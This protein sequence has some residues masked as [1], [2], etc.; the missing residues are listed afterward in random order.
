M[1]YYKYGI[2]DSSSHVPQIIRGFRGH[3]WPPELWDRRQDVPVCCEWMS[4]EYHME[5]AALT[6][7]RTGSLGV[8]AIA[9]KDLLAMIQSA[10]DSKSS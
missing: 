5:E 1:L 9:W 3:H 8:C 6:T 4:L 10:I 2:Y 7:R